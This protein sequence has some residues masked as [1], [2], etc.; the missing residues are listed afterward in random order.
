MLTS[1]LTGAWQSC[2]LRWQPF[3]TCSGC[4]HQTKRGKYNFFIMLLLLSFLLAFLKASSIFFH[5][6]SRSTSNPVSDCLIRLNRFPDK[7]E[8]AGKKSITAKLE[9]LSLKKESLQSLVE[10]RSYL[11]YNQIKREKLPLVSQE[12]N[13]SR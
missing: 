8:I 13:L 11:L 7:S 1:V 12:N 3:Q 5:P 2:H 10:L 4:H 6:P 9:M